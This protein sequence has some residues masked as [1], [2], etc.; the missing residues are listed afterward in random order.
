M[1]AAK[2]VGVGVGGVFLFSS[3][4]EERTG[5]T[6]FTRAATERRLYSHRPDTARAVNRVVE[7]CDVCSHQRFQIETTEHS[8]TTPPI[9]HSQGR[10]WRSQ[11]AVQ[12]ISRILP[13]LSSSPSV[14]LFLVTACDSCSSSRRT[15]IRTMQGFACLCN[16]HCI[17]RCDEGN[18]R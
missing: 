18:S 5:S 17:D 6:E 16:A 7:G 12:I 3:L 11:C 13:T 8:P 2:S 10:T 4:E 15:G 14:H 1:R 9:P